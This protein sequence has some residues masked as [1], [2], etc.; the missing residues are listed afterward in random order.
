MDKSTKH[1]SLQERIESIETSL[2]LESTPKKNIISEIKKISI[3]KLPY[4]YD[5][6]NRFIDSETLHDV[7]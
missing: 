7:R 4:T 5:S 1:K 6:L 3:D 2:N